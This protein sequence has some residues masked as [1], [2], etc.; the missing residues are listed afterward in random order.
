MTSALLLTAAC[1]PSAEEDLVPTG[2]DAAVS[3]EAAASLE[4]APVVDATIASDL[5]APWSVAF[6]PDGSAL[7]TERDKA[8]VVHLTPDGDGTWSATGGG[9]VAGVDNAGEGGLMGLAVAPAG[10]SD[11]PVGSPGTPGTP[12]YVY[13][14]TS[15]D[16]RVGVATWDGTRLNQPEVIL[17]GIP[18]AGIHNGGR[19]AWGPDGL[20]YIGTGD[21]G[22]SDSAQDPTSLAGKVLRIGPDGSIPADNPDPTSPVYSTGHRNIQGLAF[23]EA[24][25]LW[26]SEFGAG[27]VD[28]LNLITAGGNYGWPIHE[29]AAEDPAYRN[30]AA[31]W[32]PTSVASPSG[33]AI[34]NGSAWVAGLRGET[35]WQVPLEGSVAGQPIPRFTEELGRLRD[36]V[37]APDGSLWLVTN[38]TDGRGTPRP[39]DD[40][41]VRVSQRT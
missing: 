39:G 19:I 17:D 11:A 40:R 31:Q 8:E 26:A 14:S 24:G 5:A 1:S 3:D 28:E 25:R 7:I 37:E 27:N 18:H 9:A 36:V 16:N 21:A 10:P 23:D 29:G 20:L 30:P 13:W 34:S 22:D 2:R 38:N 32:S 41:I 33:L 15:T 12:V 35:L 4:A 6:L